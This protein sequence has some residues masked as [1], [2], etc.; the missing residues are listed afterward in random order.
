MVQLAED[1]ICAK[2]KVTKIETVQEEYVACVGR[3]LTLPIPSLSSA[4]A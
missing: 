4:T 2:Y 1:T 3:W